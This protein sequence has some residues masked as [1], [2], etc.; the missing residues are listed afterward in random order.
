MKRYN[1]VCNLLNKKEIIISEQF[2]ELIPLFYHLKVK[3]QMML[4]ANLSLAKGESFRQKEKDTLVRFNEIK[5]YFRSDL[6]YSNECYYRVLSNN[7]YYMY[8]IFRN[9]KR[10]IKRILRR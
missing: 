8:K 3:I 6:P 5:N 9:I 4:L 2:P 7:M 10:N 1:D